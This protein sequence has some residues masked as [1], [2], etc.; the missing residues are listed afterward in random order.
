MCK[1]SLSFTGLYAKVPYYLLLYMQKC[2]YFL[3]LYDIMQKCPC[4]LLLYMQSSDR[5][6]RRL[7]DRRGNTLPGP[8]RVPP[9]PAALPSARR[10]QRVRHARR[11]P[12]AA[13]EHLH[14]AVLGLRFFVQIMFPWV[15]IRANMLY[16]AAHTLNRAAS[17]SAR[18]SYCS[19]A[20]VLDRLATTAR[21]HHS[22]RKPSGEPRR[23]RPG[24]RM[25]FVRFHPPRILTALD[26]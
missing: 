4:S 20:C 15:P 17:V 8:Q 5:G 1:V 12:G 7:E 11:L 24:S 13:L 22:Y 25:Q 2:S 6:G 21:K 19:F 9:M 26:S 10:A 18:G 14:R 16:L 3:L 23:S